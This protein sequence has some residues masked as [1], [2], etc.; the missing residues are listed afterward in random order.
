MQ[1]QERTCK[2]TSYRTEKD[3]NTYITKLQKTSTRNVG[4]LR[5]YLCSDCKLWHLTSRPLELYENPAVT[6]LKAEI[7]EL[8]LKH[9]EREKEL[10]KEIDGFKSKLKE[11]ESKLKETELK[12]SLTEKRVDRRPIAQRVHE[13]ADFKDVKKKLKEANIK[14]NELQAT[15]SKLTKENKK[16]THELTEIKKIKAKKK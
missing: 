2:K 8:K 16:I 15:V 12:L 5:A 9:A 3:A 11:S 13:H 6:Q 7:E 1:T 4:Y 10:Q 14:N